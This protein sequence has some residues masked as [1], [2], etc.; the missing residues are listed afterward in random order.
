MALALVKIT[1]AAATQDN[2]L[3]FI[4]FLPVVE[5]IPLSIYFNCGVIQPAISQRLY[6]HTGDFM[7][8]ISNKM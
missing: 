2:N 3:F 5:L 8:Q 6:Y 4:I 7:L 1:A